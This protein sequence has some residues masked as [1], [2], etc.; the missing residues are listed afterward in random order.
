[1]T[2]SWMDKK[3][4]LADYSYDKYWAKAAGMKFKLKQRIINK[5]LHL[6]PT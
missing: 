4:N 2:F 3:Y 1:M 5:K 6:T